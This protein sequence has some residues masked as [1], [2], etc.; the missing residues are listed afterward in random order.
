MSFPKLSAGTLKMLAMSGVATLAACQSV[1][2]TSLPA[3]SRLDPF[4]LDPAALRAAVTHQSSLRFVPGETVMLMRVNRKQEGVVLEETF[5]LAQAPGDQSAPTEPGTLTTVLSVRN[6]D[7]DR[8]NAFQSDMRAI[9]DAKTGK[10]SFVISVSPAVCTDA[11][12]ESAEVSIYISGRAGDGF[13]PVARKQA[14]DEV[15]VC[16][17]TTGDEG[18]KNG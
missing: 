4:S 3:L 7:R 9:R 1:P 13:V 14:V 16:Q 12:A 15:R 18:M 6:E 5:A 2:V 11:A 8:F 17:T 10:H